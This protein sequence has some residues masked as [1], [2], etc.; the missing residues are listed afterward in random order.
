MAFIRRNH[1][2]SSNDLALAMAAEGQQRSGR[3]MTETAWTLWWFCR[4][5]PHGPRQALEAALSGELL[6][7]TRPRDY[8]TRCWL[9]QTRVQRIQ[10]YSVVQHFSSLAE[11]QMLR[12]PLRG[13]QEIGTDR[14]KRKPGGH[15]LPLL[16]GRGH[17][18]TALASPP[19]PHHR[20]HHL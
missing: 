16:M 6:H 20:A 15:R 13:L 18:D 12:W 19:G 2:G 9:K 7:T 14:G 1:G 3:G 17:W 8:S 10:E 11:G 4:P 5:R